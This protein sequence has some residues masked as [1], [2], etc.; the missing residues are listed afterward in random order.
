M[1]FLQDAFAS[2]VHI[3]F[4]D[5]VKQFADYWH[6]Y[7]I[8]DEHSVSPLLDKP[9][10]LLIGYHSRPTIDIMYFVCSLRCH[11]IV[12]DLLF[13]IPILGQALPLFRVLP[14][15]PVQSNGTKPSNSEY[16]ANV[17]TSIDH[18]LLLLPGGEEECH[19]QYDEM[20]QLKWKEVP[21]FVRSIC[22]QKALGQQT[23]VIPFYTKHCED[24][25]LTTPS[26]YNYSAKQAAHFM[27]QFRL[28]KNILYLPLVLLWLLLCFGNSLCPR[29]IKLDTYLGA[30]I[31]LAADE[32]PEHF[33]Q[34]IQEATNRLI[35]EKNASPERPF[36]D[37]PPNPVIATLVALLLGTVVLISH[38]IGIGLLGGVG[39]LLIFIIQQI[40]NLFAKKRVDVQVKKDE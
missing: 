17:L 12:T 30:P 39:C 26:W 11:V 23:S 35:L 1:E 38:V 5:R 2:F 3:I 14:S 13:K 25:F 10:T 34:R 8:H 40:F 21:G 37:G 7:E 18:P 27:R 29:V 19:K 31:V 36:P 28:T 24:I 16:F 32:S 33:S 15:R 9:N 22:K 4:I 20:Y 6:G